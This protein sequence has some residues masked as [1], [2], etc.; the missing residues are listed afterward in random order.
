[1]MEE[2]DIWKMYCD[3]Q[4]GPS[5]PEEDPAQAGAADADP[6][7]GS[8]AVKEDP[9]QTAKPEVKSEDTA[10]AVKKEKEEEDEEDAARADTRPSP[11][12]SRKLPTATE[13]LD[14]SSVVASCRAM[15]DEYSTFFGLQ[16]TV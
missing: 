10:I 14:F 11:P 15:I 3:I 6:K 16:G 13:K 8:E 4:F 2:I 12:A 1:M 9:Y 7:D 5:P